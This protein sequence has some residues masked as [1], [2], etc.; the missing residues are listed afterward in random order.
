MV[1]KCIDRIESTRV[2]HAGLDV[3]STTAKVV[4]LDGED[5]VLFSRYQRHLADTKTVIRQLVDEIVGTYPD[6]EM[7]IAIAGS[8]GIAL[9]ESMGVS[10][11]QEIVA[12][13]TSISYFFPKVDVCIELGG[14]DA[15]L[16]FFDEGGADQRMNET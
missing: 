2:L 4:L 9:A 3:G 6:S 14:E 11:A 5:N 8:G 12:C 7:T 13:S 15:K 16:I 1:F 10:F